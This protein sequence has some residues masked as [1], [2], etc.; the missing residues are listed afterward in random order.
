MSNS[1]GIR[2]LTARE[3]NQVQA[4]LRLARNCLICRD[5]SEPL[6]EEAIREIRA[7][8]E[9]LIRKTRKK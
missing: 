2:V 6:K 3:A 7:S 5:V 4:A 9:T 1:D 8:Q